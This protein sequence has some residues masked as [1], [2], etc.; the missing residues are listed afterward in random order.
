MALCPLD[1]IYMYI[2]EIETS[3]CILF[4]NKCIYQVKYFRNIW[5]IIFKSNFEILKYCMSVIKISA[6]VPIISMIC[7]ILS[8]MNIEIDCYKINDV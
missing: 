5:I 4:R 6:W 3:F 7:G 1:F 8:M 2:Q